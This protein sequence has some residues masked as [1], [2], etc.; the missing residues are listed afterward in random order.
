VE[1]DF[2]GVLSDNWGLFSSISSSES[3]GELSLINEVRRI[4]YV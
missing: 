4:L 3:G 2:L 1:V